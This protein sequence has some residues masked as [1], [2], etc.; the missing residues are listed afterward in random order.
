MN[1][2]KLQNAQLEAVADI[3]RKAL[4]TAKKMGVPKTYKDYNELLKDSNIDAVII[5]LPTHLHASSAKAAAE[6]N[7]HILLE[8]PLARNPAEGREI[9]ETA[10]KHNVKLMI[11]HPIR[12]STINRQ[13]KA[14]I[15][16]GEL[17]EIQI[18]YA[19]N[20]SS[21]PFMHRSQDQA[22][23]P[24]PEWWWNRELTGG[25]ALIDLGSHM[26]DLARWFF[27][28]VTD[29]KAYLGHRYNLDQEDHAICTLKFEKGTIAVI[30]VGW[31]SQQTQMELEV[32]GTAGH[33]STTQKAPNKIKTALQLMLRQTPSY[34]LPFLSEVQHL[35]DCIQQDKQPEPSGIDGLRNLEVIQKAYQNEI[36]LV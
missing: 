22:P 29:A 27:G 14:R 28:E 26:I 8:K 15:A 4:N 19:T 25:G 21:G 32:Y 2:Q 6:A 1:C 36:K 31:F 35:V 23:V 17:G 13:L 12:F 10:G 18:A 34:Y 16:S 3:S 33:A 30:N 11:G 24:V 7:K 20:I 9:L 5:S